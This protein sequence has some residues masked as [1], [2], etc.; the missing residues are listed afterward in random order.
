MLKRSAS[1]PC[2]EK[3]TACSTAASTTGGSTATH[4]ATRPWRRSPP[5]KDCSSHEA[6]AASVPCSAFRSPSGRHCSMTRAAMMAKT[7]TAFSACKFGSCED[8][9]KVDKHP[10]GGTPDGVPFVLDEVVVRGAAA[11]LARA[12]LVVARIEDE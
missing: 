8:S 6:H 7:L 12:A 4:Q 1:R 9:I 11:D 10:R 5:L 2:T 3:S